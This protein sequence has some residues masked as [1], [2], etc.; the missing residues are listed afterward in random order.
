[1]HL[2]HTIEIA[3]PPSLVWEVTA[4]MPSWPQWTP[5]MT[6]VEPLEPGPV[7]VGSRYRVKQP[8]MPAGIWTVTVLDPPERLVWETQRWGLRLVATHH[9]S[10]FGPRTRSYLALDLDGVVGQ[11]IWPV[12]QWIAPKFLV[13]ENQGLKA[14]CENRVRELQAS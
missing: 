11:V 5:T 3:A 7:G 10:A 1:M 12:F 13:Q 14:Y 6:A 8:R 4:E 2:E 9:V